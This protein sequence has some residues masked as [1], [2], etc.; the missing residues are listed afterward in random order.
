[1][2]KIALENKQFFFYYKINY[3]FCQLIYEK[4]EILAQAYKSI[5]IK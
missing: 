4:R 2:R 1:M 3:G 5:D